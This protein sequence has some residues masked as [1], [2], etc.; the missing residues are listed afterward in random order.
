MTSFTPTDEMVKESS[1]EGHLTKMIN[2]HST[3]ADKLDI[4]PWSTR[5]RL[6]RRM[7]T[8]DRRNKRG[9]GISS[10]AKPE[11]RRNHDRRYQCERR[12]GWLRVGR[13]RSVSVFDR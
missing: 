7:G 11:R 4:S 3:K 2:L 13:W 6:D 8:P 1:A 12:D 5:S 9:A 10:I